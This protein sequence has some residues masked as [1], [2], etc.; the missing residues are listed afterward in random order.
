MEKPIRVLVFVCAVAILVLALVFRGQ[1]GEQE[2]LLYHFEKGTFPEKLPDT[3]LD[4]NQLDQL[5]QRANMLV[6]E[7]SGLSGTSR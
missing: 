2:A 1:P 5:Q 6:T 3:Q 7:R 4:E